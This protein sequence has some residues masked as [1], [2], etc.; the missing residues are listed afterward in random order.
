MPDWEKEESQKRRR[1]YWVAIVGSLFAVSVVLVLSAVGF[2]G[3]VINLVTRTPSCYG[4][5]HSGPCM[6]REGT[7][8]TL[9]MFYLILT[10]PLAALLFG[11]SL[12]L[13]VW[14]IRQLRKRD[15]R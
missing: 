8:D 14:M 3:Q 15:N 2:V 1:E 11:G 10:I 6:R 7:A 4:V 12:F 9:D 13:L 5:R